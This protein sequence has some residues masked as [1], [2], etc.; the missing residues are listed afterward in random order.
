MVARDQPDPRP[1]IRRLFLSQ[2]DPHGCAETAVLVLH[3]QLGLADPS[4]GPAAMALNG[5]VAYSGGTCGALTGAAMTLGRLASERISDR[6]VAKRVARELTASVI[7]EFRAAN[8]ATDCR[9]LIGVDLCAPGG[10][11][12]F[13]AAGTWRRDCLRRIELV[14]DRVA[15]LADETA[16]AEAVTAVAAVAAAPDGPASPGRGVDF[17]AAVTHEESDRPA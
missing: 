6:S 16:W 13:I 11:E 2:R 9:T 12:A 5:G 1:E 17:A 10:H 14:V 15:P 7:D 8:G 4:L 3:Q